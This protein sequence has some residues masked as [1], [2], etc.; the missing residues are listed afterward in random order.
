MVKKKSNVVEKELTLADAIK[1]TQHIVDKVNVEIPWHVWTSFVK[2]EGGQRV[3]LHGGNIAFGKHS[4]FKTLEEQR[5][6]AEWIVEILGG[7]VKWE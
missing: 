3:E 7:K 5:C 6:A 1:E 2:L 4:D